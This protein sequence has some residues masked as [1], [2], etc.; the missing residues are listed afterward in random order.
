MSS[1]AEKDRSTWRRLGNEKEK[2]ETR[3]MWSYVND[4]GVTGQMLLFL[5]L[6]SR[7]VSGLCGSESMDAFLK[8]LPDQN[9]LGRHKCSGLPLYVTSASRFGRF[10][11]SLNDDQGRRVYCMLAKPLVERTFL[12][13]FFTL[14]PWH[15]TPDAS[16]NAILAAAIPLLFP[17]SGEDAALVQLLSLRNIPEEDPRWSDEAKLAF[18]SFLDRAADKVSFSRVSLSIMAHPFDQHSEK[19]SGTDRGQRLHSAKQKV[20]ERA[21]AWKKK[22]ASR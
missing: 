9:V 16:I 19:T 21:S 11:M 22:Y 20:L 12:E 15:L 5:D 18:S 14:F 7:R 13:T 1:L 4:M 8:A 3:R 17:T 6:L 10:N 2:E